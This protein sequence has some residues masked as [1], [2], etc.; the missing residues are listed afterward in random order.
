MKR[1][2]R[3]FL[4]CLIAL[5]A[6]VSAAPQ[7]QQ[8]KAEKDW[9][10]ELKTILVELRAVVTDNKG[11]LV[12]GLKKED[13]ELREKGHLQDISSFGEERVGPISITQRVILA[14]VNPVE[15]PAPAKE[16]ARSLLLFVDSIN[17][18]GQNLLRV[19]QG[20]KKFID[21]QITDQD[22]VMIVTSGGMEGIPARFTR[23][24]N[25]MRFYID[26]ISSWGAKSTSYFTPALAADVRRENP[27]AIKVAINLLR[28]EDGLNT[29]MLSP[30][31]LK[32]MA[33]GRASEVLAQASFRRTSLLGTFRAAAELMSKAPGQRVMFF[34]SDGFTMLDSRGNVDSIEIQQ[35]ISRAVRSGLVVFSINSKGLEAPV[36][37]D[38]SRR[39]PSFGA[40]D[41]ALNGRMASYVSASEKESQ[42]GMNAIAKD[43]GGDAF[44]RTN[45]VNFALKKSF[46]GNN[47]YYAL[48]YYPN[49]EGQ[50]FRDIA[51]SVKGHPEYSVRTQRGY[52]ASDII[53]SAKAAAAKSQQQRLFDAIARPIPETT[54]GVSA[55]AHYLEVDSD[56]AQV[57]IKLLIDG[58]HLTFHD[59]ADRA[60][61]ALEVAGTVYDRAGR[62]V[63]SFIEKIKGGVPQAHLPEVRGSGFS[64]T[65]RLELKPGYY[66]VR[67]GVLEPETDNIGTANTWVEVP[68]LAKGKLELSSVLLATSGEPQQPVNGLQQL[69]A[70]KAYKT[71]STLVYYLMLYNATTTAPSDL[72]IRS[73][74]SLNDKVIFESEPQP[75]T[76]RM[77]GRDSKGIEIGGQLNLDIEPG[78]YSLKVEIKDK[79]NREFR[80]SVEFLVTN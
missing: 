50:G 54:I 75:V 78:F 39:G 56:K 51:L 42:D 77:V 23:E 12:Q 53:K 19:K 52:L 20:L 73:E 70:I 71:G 48:A 22:A 65:K 35:A 25:L 72:T 32:Q 13:F 76:S 41:P 5:V 57:S 64:Y 67:A 46:E 37:I 2:G 10:I 68:D 34:F 11:R 49:T 63:T 79:S 15:S 24:R 44:F 27:D 28:R 31:M 26:K 40:F 16:Q 55:S 1:R 74:I 18:A 66:Q 47:V 59:M 3:L 80:R 6:S 14:N 43:T 60:N 62:L 33:L 58:G 9:V 7:D 4:S 21:E 61:L 17:M 8:K 29:E 38:A 45:D 30:Q 69:D 36:E